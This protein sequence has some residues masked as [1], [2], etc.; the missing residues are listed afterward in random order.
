[1]VTQAESPD[2]GVAASGRILPARYRVEREL[3][4]GVAAVVYLC[5]DKRD[6]GL[7]AAKVLRPEYARALAAERFVREVEFIS[8]FDHPCIPKVIDSGVT[9][10]VPFYVMTYVEG[11]ALS[12]RLDRE[13]P[14][15]IAEAVRIAREVMRPMGYAHNR[16][17]VHRDIKPENIIVSA[18]GV[19]V[20]DFGIARALAGAGGE[21]L[22]KTGLTVGTP[23][24]MSPEQAL[25]TRDLDQRSDIYSLGCVLYEMLAGALPFAASTPE[26]L[27]ARRFAGP[28]R[29]LREIRPEIPPALERAISKAMQ[30][31]PADRWPNTVEFSDALRESIA[32]AIPEP[33]AISEP[34]GAIAFVPRNEMLET[35]R[36]SFGGTYEV[37]DEMKGGGMSR[38]FVATDIELRRRVVIKILPPE[39][40]SPMML[41]RFKRESK[42][43]ARLHHP[44]I[45][46]IISAGVRDGMAHYIMP[47]FEGESLRARLRREGRLSIA[48]GVQL[49]REITDALSCAHAEGVVHRDI[50]PENILILGGHAVLADFGIA[51]ALGGSSNET[52]DRLTGTGV[53]LGT[54][55]YMSPEQALGEKNVDSRADIYSIGVIGF[56]IFAGCTPFTG[57]TDHAIL[58]AHLTR[59]PEPLERYRADAPVGV[60]LAIRKALQKDPASRFQ[61]ASEFREA[62]DRS[63]LSPTPPLPSTP[64]NVPQPGSSLR[65]KLGDFLKALR[66]D[67]P[68]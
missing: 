24:Y 18:A 32:V 58:V 56:E 55:G 4:R 21:R 22:T 44:H 68:N 1:M 35:L 10:G 5:T 19:Y 42:I 26:A 11:E 13:R 39:L 8:N 60:G 6:G 59:D 37:E 66:T 51:S 47:F 53:S 34:A 16:A 54:V 27:L 31:A 12:S 2:D 48:E 45:L 25:G 49:L 50:K 57:E 30:Q 9:A 43:T 15:P 38:L 14:L 20:L 52:G 33:S 65:S 28:P 64:V 46:P 36:S 67:G 62:L 29:P 61:T 7:V 17:I 23:A 63:I 3:G 41:A 40:T